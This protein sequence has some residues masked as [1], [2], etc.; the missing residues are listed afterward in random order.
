MEAFGQ[1]V[2]Q[3]ASNELVRRERHGLLPLAPLE[4]V[5]FVLE[6]DAP[7]VEGD[8]AAV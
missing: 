3:E 6:G 7:L 4:P 2:A 8:Q 1:D 5:V